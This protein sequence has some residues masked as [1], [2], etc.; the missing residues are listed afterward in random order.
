MDVLV[1]EKIKQHLRG[2]LYTCGI[3]AMIFGII[4][5]LILSKI[6]KEDPPDEFLLLMVNYKFWLIVILLT[7]SWLFG[8][9]IIKILVR[10]LFYGLAI[11]FCLT[12]IADLIFNVNFTSFMLSI[13]H[14]AYTWLFSVGAAGYK[15]VKSSYGQ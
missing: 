11:S 5:S 8:W 4:S 14:S 2:F 7:I 1:A 13:W 9:F 12:F 10:T 3:V 15:V 6:H